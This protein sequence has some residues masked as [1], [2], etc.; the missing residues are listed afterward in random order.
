M[1]LAQFNKLDKAAA[2]ELLATTC[3]S[4]RWQELMMEKFPFAS[5]TAMVKTAADL[6]YDGCSRQDW[7]EAFA[8]HPKIGETQNLEEKFPATKHLASNEQAGVKTAPKDMIDL[9]ARANDLYEAK[10]GFI[11]IVFATGKS[12]AEMLRILQDRSSNNYEEE[13]IIAI[14]EQLKITIQRFKKIIDAAD[15]VSVKP[16]QITTHVLDTSA[17]CPA[18]SMTIR[19]K[20]CVNNA[21]T[22]LAQG[23]TN[24][25]GR[26]GDLLPSGKNAVPGNYKMVFETSNYFKLNNIKGFYPVVEI[27]FTVWD[28]TH[29]HVPLL[30]NAFGYS[31]YRGS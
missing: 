8:Q 21:W 22:T 19:L 28:E 18:S 15:W 20:H 27:N 14:G 12:A 30:L 23:V 13:I 9:L 11:F 31:T 16:S 24:T 2:K 1:T 6:W 3:G 17:G 25:D 26:I 5:E 10:F 4:G 29:Y 7:M